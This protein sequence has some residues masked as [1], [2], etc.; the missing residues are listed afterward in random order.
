MRLIIIL[1]AIGVT[2]GLFDLGAFVFTPKTGLVVFP[3]Y[4][5]VGARLSLQEA[6]RAYPRNYHIPDEQMGFDIAPNQPPT[7][8]VMPDKTVTIFSNEL[9][10]MDRNTLTLIQHAPSYEYITGDSFTWGY[11]DY[12]AKYP[13]VYEIQANRV[14]AKCGITHSGQAHQFEK[15]QRVVK[16]IGHYPNRVIIGYF[17]NDVINDYLYPHTTVIEGFQI[18]TVRVDDRY[19]VVQRNL[20]EVQNTIL[21]SIEGKFNGTYKN[22][23]HWMQTYSLSI[24]LLSFGVQKASSPIN[25]ET[26]SI[27]PLFNFYR[28]AHNVG[29]DQSYL[30]LPITEANRRAIARWASDAKAHSY[31]LVFLLIPT[32]GGYAQSSSY[33]GLKEYL[34]GQQIRYINLATQFQ[35]SGK[36][37]DH[38]YWEH[39]GHWNNEGNTYVGNY[40]SQVLGR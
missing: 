40:L 27:R 3:A 12:D 30:S 8:F 39:D 22:L 5:G 14:V 38:F 2:L 29:I 33:P 36:S 9:G 15:F 28:L 13:S 34:R 10:C 6:I 19:Q 37:V 11:A 20:G 1:L 31:E 35:Q 32:K 26:H 4:K 23:L 25:T 24:N 17:E 16:A 7:D 21:Q 18:D